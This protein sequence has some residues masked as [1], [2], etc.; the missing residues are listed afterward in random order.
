MTLLATRTDRAPRTYVLPGRHRATVRRPRP[1]TTRVQY[2]IE[3]L[4]DTGQPTVIH[5]GM[6]HVRTA[7]QA[8]LDN[9]VATLALDQLTGNTCQ[10]KIRVSASTT[11]STGVALVAYITVECRC[12]IVDPLERLRALLAGV[13]QSSG[14][15]S[16]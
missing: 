16:L 5:Q 2:A 9:I 8:T 14:G 3:T 12:G 6:I 10:N 4:P 11:T 1:A 7:E 15:A 13:A